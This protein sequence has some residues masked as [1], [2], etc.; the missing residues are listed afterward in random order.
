MISKTVDG[1]G[2]CLIAHRSSRLMFSM[3]QISSRKAKIRISRPT[4]VSS[5]P[6]IKE[7]ATRLSQINERTLRKILALYS[8][9]SY[10]EENL[11]FLEKDDSLRSLKSTKTSKISEAGFRARAQ[12]PRSFVSSGKATMKMTPSDPDGHHQ[13]RL[14]F[15]DQFMI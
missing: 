15:N 6:Q 9:I 5:T 14:H 4:F 11:S 7:G 3:V 8:Y 13:D 1:D 2:L 12:N 10:E